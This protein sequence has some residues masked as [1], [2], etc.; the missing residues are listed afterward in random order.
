MASKVEEDFT[1]TGCVY[2]QTH[3]SAHYWHHGTQLMGRTSPNFSSKRD[4]SST[5][6]FAARLRSTRDASSIS[7]KEGAQRESLFTR[8]VI[9]YFFT[10]A[11][12]PT[13]RTCAPSSPKR[14]LMKCTTSRRNHTSRLA[15]KCPSTPRMWMRLERPPFERYSHVRTRKEDALLP[16]IDVGLYG[17]VQEIPQKETTPF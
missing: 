6:S 4:T 3:G 11:I 13:H 17:K 5:A 2:A 14:V 1:L 9:A 12:S 16:S 8:L 10:T 15:L 7:S